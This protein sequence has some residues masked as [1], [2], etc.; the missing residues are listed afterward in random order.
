VLAF[1]LYRVLCGLFRMLV[2]VGVDDRDLE[3]AV[4]RLS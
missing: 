3:I 4:L 1:L 2:P